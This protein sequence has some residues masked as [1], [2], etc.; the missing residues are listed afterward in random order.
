LAFL[1]AGTLL[2][3][4]NQQQQQ[5]QKPP[6]STPPYV[7][8]Q[9]IMVLPPGGTIPQGPAQPS[10]PPQQQKP[11]AQPAAQPQA[12]PAGPPPSAQT[13]AAAAP[14]PAPQGTQPAQAA[15]PPPPSNVSVP[16]AL[17]LTGASLLEV[18]DLLARDLH[19]NYILDPRVKGSV[20]INT[21]GEI[22]AMDLR[23][24][25][26]TILRMNGFQMVQVGNMYRIVPVNEAA[27]LPVAPEANATNLPD[28]ERLILNLV[29]LKF[30]TAAE[31]SK[32]LEPFNGEGAKMI[33]Y[34]PANLLILEDNS[35]NMRRTMEL[36]AMFDS[37]TLAGQRVRAY[38]LSNGRPSDIA[39][40]LETIFK[41]YAFSEKSASVHFLPVDR[42]NT[43]IAV[44][45]NPGSFSKVEE[46]V[47][48][49]DIPAK[50]P[51]G[52]V[53]NHVYRLKYGR[54][55]ILGAVI[56]QLYGGYG[57]SS[58]PGYGQTPFGNVSGTGFPVNG[59]FGGGGSGGPFGSGLGAGAMGAG[60]AGGGAGG[61]GGST[62]AGGSASLPAMQG[63]PS[64]TA[65]TVNG[66]PLSGPGGLA[67]ANGMNPNS[68]NQ[69]GQYLGNGMGGMNG[70]LPRII[71]NP[72]DNTLLVQS[73][74]EQWAQIEALLTQLDIAPRQVLIDAK[75]YEVDLSGDLQYGVEW[76]LQ[77][78]D[79][80]NTAAAGLTRQL[81]GTAGTAGVSLSTGFMA[82][83]SRELLAA[84]TASDLATKTKMVASP[85][86]IATDSIPATI[87]VGVDV[88]TLQSQAVTGIQS[89]GSSLF[90]NTI[91]SRSTGVTLGLV[92]RINASGIVTLVINQE[93]SQPNYP[94]AGAAIQSPSF[95]QRSVS[96][97]VTVGDGDT[98][99]IG[100]II[101]ENSGVTSAGV[102]F[103][104]RIP[105]IGGAF[106]TKH[107]T[108]SRS[109]LLIFL[110]PRVI[111]DMN[112]V[113]DATEDLKERMKSL[114]RIIKD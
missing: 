84:V 39:K 82:G 3:G 37:D 27:R 79:N 14:A 68:L 65:G 66:T 104:S 12:A 15:A 32:L 2:F 70:G 51:V 16:A 28:D 26:E 86:I 63:F 62:A 110:T 77:R 61:L 64:P 112:Q 88:P 95:T 45:P 90:A 69:T 113:Q 78:K 5:Q 52:S 99:A 33:A 25:L 4:Q 76:Y 85:S 54:A 9:P 30:A 101:Q 10:P 53:D 74:P 97:Q 40:E 29:F 73:T 47:K 21:Y 106:G 59:V 34:E 22:K 89:G 50:P 92:A 94:S 58:F 48:K 7:Q 114:K 44:A 107:W 111:Y 24:L 80:P 55:E 75:I 56:S 46:W 43:L 60:L 6:V 41:A 18:I 1:F 103:L 49:L 38:T 67:M 17:N 72:Y 20:T 19:I 108:N 35:R 109:E 105:Y 96:T 23:P 57:G 8:S 87:N 93:F 100:G 11:A 31:I 98:I 81:V 42:I 13:P 83:R 102:P 71:P 91:G 36:I